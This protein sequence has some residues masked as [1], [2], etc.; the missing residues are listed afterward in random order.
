MLAMAQKVLLIGWDAADW[1][2]IHELMDAGKMP[3]LEGLVKRGSMGNLRTLRPALSP[4]L[5][6]SIATGKRPFKHGITGFYEPSPDGKSIL[7]MTNLSRSTKAIWN[8]FN[9]NQLRSLVVGWWPS[10]PAEPI[11]GVM[12]SDLFHKAPLKPSD[13]WPLQSGCVHPAS[14][15]AELQSLRI[16]PS[17]IMAEDVLSFVPHAVDIDQ[18]SDGRLS[19]VMKITAECSSIQAAATH[20]L[21]HEPWDFA[22]V[23]Y[24][25]IDHYSHGF[26]RYRAP[27]Q[28]FVKDDEYRLYRHVVDMGYIYHDMMLKQLLVHADDQTTVML[29]SDHGFHSDHLRPSRIPSEAAGPVVE[30]RDYGIIVAAGPQ[31]RSDHLIHGANLLDVTPTLLQLSGLPVG[32]D[33]DGRVLTELFV[34]EPKV[35]MIESWEEVSGNSG[36]HAAGC[37]ISIEDSKTRIDQL[38]ALGYIDEPDSDSSKAVEEC[39]REL[40]YNLARSYID[41]ELHGYAAPMLLALYEKYPLEFRFGIQL[42]ACFIVL[43]KQV[44]LKLLVDDMNDRWR[45]SA[46]V[47]KER[48]REVAQIVKERRKMLQVI[49]AFG[50]ADQD[51]TPAVVEPSG[52][53]RLLSSHEQQEVQ[54]LRSI[55]R[56]STEALDF[57][58]AS[59]AAMEGDHEH[60][61][62]LLEKAETS[63]SQGVML[64]FQMSNVYMKLGRFLDAKEVLLK[65]LEQDETHVRS[66]V[67]LSR[68]HVKLGSFAEALEYARR[69]IGLQYQCPLAHYYVARAQRASGQFAAAIPSLE[70]ALSQNPNFAEA[71]TELASLYSR[72]ENTHELAAKHTVLA[73]ELIAENVAAKQG[74]P[75]VTFNPSSI[76]QISAEMPSWNH[77]E[78]NS[79]LEK[80]LGQPISDTSEHREADEPAEVVVVSGLPRSGTSMMM[81]MLAAGGAPIFTDGNREA[82]ENNRRGYLE[83]DLVKTLAKNNTWVRDCDGKV[84]KVV[85]PLLQF[86]PQSVR[87]KVV[88]MTRPVAQVV[89]SQSRMLCRLG[90]GDSREDDRQMEISLRHE[91][92]TALA[93]LSYHQVQILQVEYANAVAQPVKTAGAVAEFLELP[94]D[95][96]AMA[97]AV[98]PQLHRE[99]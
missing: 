80:S 6:T 2:V 4:M 16:H 42:A 83:A 89:K 63:N 51:L 55:S 47:A 75:A 58:A 79:N 65:G 92:Q 74:D 61:L 76:Q 62:R 78:G 34:D 60:S 40:N 18:A 37:E 66:L 39:R 25:A 3:T 13:Q 90:N 21:E 94:L 50:Q 59:V 68:C 95:E 46:Q 82:D 17:E 31:I 87:F 8:I 73:E 64:N 11:D 97:E 10:H 24:D 14:M 45:K 23:Y 98:E 12:V 29:I 85:A 56:G 9:Q 41:A 44:D 67:A 71:H 28:S 20:L 93:L 22:A 84:V 35:K 69:A 77:N 53:R 30:H 70:I 19:S 99:R 81:Q 1:K 7:P 36:E 88:F 86:L 32:Q 91:K 52:R 96:I 72:G 5:W 54:K 48:L 27:Q 26:M 43:E 49:E 57:L 38:V 15:L 33:M